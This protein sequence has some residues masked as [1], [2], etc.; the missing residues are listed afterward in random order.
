MTRLALKI[1]V[2]TLR[3]TLDGVPRLVSLLRRRR[4]NA[5]FLFSLGPDNTG[6]ALRRIFRR[7]FL[8]KVLRTSVGANYGLKTL[9]YGVLWPGPPI[10]RRAE[11]QLRAVRDA[12]FEVGV[13]CHDHVLWQ[14]FVAR[15]DR[16]W[17]ERQMSLAVNEFQR[18]FGTPPKIHG[19]A[20]WQ[21]NEF[22]PELEAQFGIQIASDTRGV[23]PFRP[24]SAN[25]KPNCVQLP[26]TLP[27][28][29]EIIGL[30]GC[31][32][33]NVA[34]RILRLTAAQ[35]QRDQVFTLHAEIEGLRLTP[36]FESLLEGWTRAG[37]TL[38]SLGELSESLDPTKI[39]VQ[40][41]VTGEVPG[42][43]GTLACQAA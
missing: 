1:D 33:T 30:D 15:R 37:I 35:P 11:A 8:T 31:T 41:I 3:G 34:D 13:H 18:I 23:S 27:T 5:T 7:G 6:R 9:T 14:D 4:V 25:G 36:V 28:A 38:C 26:T 29:D 16:P 24:T 10:G 32:E 20:G 12:G 40:R 19:S 39:P 17:T 22:V 2:D 42:R 43:S 21:M